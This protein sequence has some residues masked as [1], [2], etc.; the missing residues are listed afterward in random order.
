VR[1]TL[2]NQAINSLAILKQ[3]NYVVHPDPSPG[4]DGIS[5]SDGALPRDINVLRDNPR[6]WISFIRYLRHTVFSLSGL[7]A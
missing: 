2:R 3:T 4:Y 7:P 6:T 5:A 1:E